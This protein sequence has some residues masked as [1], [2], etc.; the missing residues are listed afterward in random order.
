M[1]DFSDQLKIFTA[2]IEDLRVH[3]QTEEATKTAIVLPFFQLLGYDVFNPLEFV[4]EFT[5]DVGIKKGEKVDYAVMKDGLPV[6]LIE[7]KSCTEN[8]G[9]HGSQLFRYFGTTKAKFSILTNGIIYQ[10]FTDLEDKNKMDE[11]PFLE[12]DLLN[13]KKNQISELMKFQ[14]IDFDVNVIANTASEL[15]YTGQIQSYFAQQLKDPSD[16]FSKMIINSCYTGAKTQAVIE[17]FK[18]VVKRALNQ[19]ISD[20]MNDK[21]TGALY[22]ESKA[23]E[24]EKEAA[25]AKHIDESKVVTTEAELEAFFMIKS[26]LSEY[27]STKRLIAKDTETY[28]GVL[29][30]GNIRKW[31]CRLFIKTSKIWLWLPGEGK[32]IIKIQLM[33]L[34][35]IYQHKSE[36]IHVL[37]GYLP[38]SKQ[39]KIYKGA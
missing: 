28:F 32:D 10:F 9:F 37:C 11:K 14:K 30:D 22:A 1:P 13:L 29:L 35:D 16:D 23:V 34:E 20:M 24:Q 27:I 19:Y 15:K 38:D 8:L 21:I 33:E 2:R 5:A 7:C 39:Y 6:M 17:R 31:I 25:L 3:L 12:V 26:I 36:L 18:P 4:P